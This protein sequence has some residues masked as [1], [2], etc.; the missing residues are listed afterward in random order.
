MDVIF[1]NSLNIPKKFRD[2]SK[3]FSNIFK[4]FGVYFKNVIPVNVVKVSFYQFSIISINEITIELKQFKKKLTLRSVF[5]N[6]VQKTWFNL[7]L[8]RVSRLLKI[9]LS[10]NLIKRTLF[11]VSFFLI[12]WKKRMKKK[13]LFYNSLNNFL[14]N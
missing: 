11:S 6:F 4:Q 8:F 14:V 5:R 7:H 13:Q 10:G 12:N 2:N 9:L 1:I 3:Y